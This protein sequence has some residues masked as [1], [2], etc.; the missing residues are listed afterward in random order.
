MKNVKWEVPNSPEKQLKFT[1]IFMKFPCQVRQYMTYL[2]ICRSESS[3]FVVVS[4]TATPRV[5]VLAGA[6]LWNKGLYLSTCICCNKNPIV[7]S[8]SWYTVFT[9]VTQFYD[10][11]CACYFSALKMAIIFSEDGLKDIMPLPCVLQQF[12]NHNATLYKVIIL[13]YYMKVCAWLTT[14]SKL[15]CEGISCL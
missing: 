7:V 4:T 8:F 10:K 5:Q 11:A 3:L 12:V 2:H 9:P 1:L 15:A 13:Y 6:A 14:N